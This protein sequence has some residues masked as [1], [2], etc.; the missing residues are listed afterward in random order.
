MNDHLASREASF[1]TTASVPPGL[2]AK[3]FDRIS[4]TVLTTDADASAS[5][6]GNAVTHIRRISSAEG[7]SGIVLSD[8]QR[9]MLDAVEACEALASTEEATAVDV[10]MPTMADLVSVLDAIKTNGGL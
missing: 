2:M 6:T 3:R 9:A 4:R 10:A 1:T 7:N 5:T 8:I